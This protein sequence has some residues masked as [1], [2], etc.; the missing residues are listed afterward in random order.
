MA[1]LVPGQGFKDF[2]VYEKTGTISSSGSV[3]RSVNFIK[4]TDLKGITTSMSPKERETWKQS[5]YEVSDKIVQYGSPKAKKGQYIVYY[6]FNKQSH[7]YEVKGVRNPGGLNHFSIYLVN[8]RSDLQYFN[9][10]QQE[11]ITYQASQLNETEVVK[12]E[13]KE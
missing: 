7:V 6:D 13:V 10:L 3:G 11:L 2:V 12:L 8:E 5:G 9:N 4:K 1:F